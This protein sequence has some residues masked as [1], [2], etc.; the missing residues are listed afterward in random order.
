MLLTFIAKFIDIV[1][2]KMFNLKLLHKITYDVQWSP[3]SCGIG[4]LHLSNFMC[5]LCF[6]ANS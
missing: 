5:N 1:Q 4:K 6:K 3:L 2:N